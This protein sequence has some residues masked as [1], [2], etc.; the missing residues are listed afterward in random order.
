M[1]DPG[2]LIK[3]EKWWTDKGAPV[4]ALTYFLLAIDRDVLTL[5]RMLVALLAFIAT[6][7]GVAG[8]GHIVNDIGDFEYDRI[9]GKPNALHGKAPG[10]VALILVALL[11]LAWV[12]WLLLPAN[13]WNLSLIGLQLLLLTVYALPP[14][15]LKV[16][17]LPGVLT[18]ALY[19]Y[20]V[21]ALITWTTWGSM[22]GPMPRRSFLLAVL[23]PWSLCAGVRGILNHQLLDEED[24][25]RAGITTLVT[26]Y[27][28]TRTQWVLSRAVLPLEIL[29]FGL[30]TIAFTPDL[31]LYA[32]GVVLFVGWQMFQIVYLWG[33][34][35]LD[36]HLAPPEQFV[37]LTGHRLL[38]EYYRLWFPLFML[39]ALVHRSLIYLPIAAAHLLLFQT[40]IGQLST[41]DFRYVRMQFGKCVRQHV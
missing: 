32:P 36:P 34:P 35:L 40:G 1:R 18:D 9:A 23:V 4:F 24:D 2:K 38:G 37:A 13:R 28:R 3:A 15:R 14:F 11:C 20:T 30:M 19:A 33:E 5:D 10:R 27:G 16:R 26:R 21:P 22:A 31:P 25:R 7:I 17:A 41:Y 39:V 6:F 12:P 8:Y 29:C